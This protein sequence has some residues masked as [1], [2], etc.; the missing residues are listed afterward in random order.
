M[1]INRDNHTWS[2]RILV[3]IH[4]QNSS[5]DDCVNSNWHPGRV[6]CKQYTATQLNENKFTPLVSQKRLHLAFLS[7]IDSSW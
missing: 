3:V 7:L 1:R 5:P 4:T 2:E 6:I